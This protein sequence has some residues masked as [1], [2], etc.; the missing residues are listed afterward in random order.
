MKKNAVVLM[1]IEK[2]M[3]RHCTGR[4]CTDWQCTDWQCTDWQCT[5]WHFTGWHCIHLIGK[6]NK[7]R[8]RIAASCWTFIADK[9]GTYDRLS[10]IL[11]FFS[12][13][14]YPTL[15]LIKV[16]SHSCC[17]ASHCWIKNVSIKWGFDSS[18]GNDMYIGDVR[19][20]VSRKK[21]Q[22]SIKV[23]QNRFH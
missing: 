3:S 9:V 15:A 12:L 5:G 16:D 7:T 11:F 19:I 4:H 17:T 13:R 10:I 23:A 21:C 14:F 22:M 1:Q 20:S 6:I 2:F 18:E 8:S